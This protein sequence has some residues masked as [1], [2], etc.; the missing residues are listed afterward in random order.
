MLAQF[1]RS[2]LFIEFIEDLLLFFFFNTDKIEQRASLGDKPFI[3]YSQ[4]FL[5]ESPFHH[6]QTGG[7]RTLEYLRSLFFRRL[8]LSTRSRIRKEKGQGLCLD[9]LSISIIMFTAFG[10]PKSLGTWAS[11]PG[12]GTAGKS[13]SSQRA[14]TATAEVQG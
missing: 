13:K 11:I 6:L 2:F 9:V 7:Q 10:S 5:Y 8:L 3:G 4:H 14:A 1:F 12:E